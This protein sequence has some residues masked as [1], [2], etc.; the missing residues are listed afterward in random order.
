MDP[1]IRPARADDLGAIESIVR[2]AYGHYRARL[3]KE[4]GPMLDDYQAH[5]GGGRI[6]VLE[7][8]GLLHG[9]VVLIP[10]VGTMFLDN[11]AVRPDAQGRGYGRQLIDFAEAEAMRL[12]YSS[13]RLYTNVAMTEN[14][15]LYG[16]LGFIETHR[17]E[18]KGFA[19][20][21]M[22]KALRPGPPGSP[23]CA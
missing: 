4:P 16:R 5:I 19:R 10:E 21:Y 11:V 17:G 15:S 23:A 7:E 20:V 14:L 12:G 2:E 13:I 8:N 18:E 22:Q 3:G 9:L 1:M 6:H